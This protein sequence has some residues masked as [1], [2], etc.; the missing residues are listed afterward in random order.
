[1]SATKDTTKY[2]PTPAVVEV[3]MKSSTTT[4]QPKKKYSDKLHKNFS[5]MERAFTD[6]NKRIAD[7]V[8]QGLG[9]WTDRREASAFKKKNGAYKDGLKNFSKALRKTLK[10]GAEAPADFLDTLSKIKI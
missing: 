4:D 8:A 9:E 2:E 5:L 3:E 6:A 10:E 1:M 7:A